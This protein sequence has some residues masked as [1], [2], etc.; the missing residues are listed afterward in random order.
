MA[1]DLTDFKKTQ[2]MAAKNARMA[3][4]DVPADEQTPLQ[5][6]KISGCNHC[7]WLM[8]VL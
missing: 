8:S 6:R 2:E 7:V 4:N 1:I 3:K 5:V